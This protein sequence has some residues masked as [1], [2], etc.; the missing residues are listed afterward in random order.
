M[1]T[2]QIILPFLFLFLLLSQV[3][4]VT[5]V[6]GTQ[7]SVTNVLYNYTKNI[8]FDNITV[9]TDFVIFNDQTFNVTPSAGNLTINV[10]EHIQDVNYSFNLT[11]TETA[12]ASFNITNINSSLDV[13][14]NDTVIENDTDGV[15]NID[16]GTTITTLKIYATTAVEFLSNL[17]IGFGAMILGVQTAY[18]AYNYYRRRRR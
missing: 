9:D 4:A 12:V 18:E 8:T 7:I 5:M 11:C 13:F 15:F 16:V 2:K 6:E 10:I 3:M 14:E 1:I 17:T